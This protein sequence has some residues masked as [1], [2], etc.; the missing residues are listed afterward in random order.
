MLINN[1][2]LNSSGAA[3][4]LQRDTSKD[5]TD[6]DVLREHHKFLW[7]EGEEVDTW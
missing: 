1:Y 2:L 4:L 5:K 3:N 7:K 6:K